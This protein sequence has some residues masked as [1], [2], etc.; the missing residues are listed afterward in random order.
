VSTLDYALGYA[1][2][3]G[4]PMLPIRPATKEPLGRLAPNGVHDAT[5]DPTIIREWFEREPDAGIAVATGHPGPQI[6]DVDDPQAA[7]DALARLRRCGAPTAATF[8]G[9]HFVFKGTDARTVAL[10]YG[11]LRGRGSYIILPPTWHPSGRQYTWLD[12]PRGPLPP[13]PTWLVPATATTAGAGELEAPTELVPYGQRH[14]YLSDL[15][16][17][18]TRAGVTDERH[19]VVFLRTAC[20][21]FCVLDPLPRRGYFE[22]L[23]GWAAATRIAERERAAA[24]RE[25]RARARGLRGGHR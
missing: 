7:G 11:E 4:W 18:F 23:A 13:V 8:R 25:A 5:T 14:P 20:V 21:M 17:R 6:A 19:L 10:G 15:A 1:T 12:S 3:F 16:V 24:H 2:R 9:L 22:K